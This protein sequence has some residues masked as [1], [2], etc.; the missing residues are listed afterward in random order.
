MDE[1]T[2]SRHRSELFPD[3]LFEDL[4][5]SDCGRPSIP[6]D[7]FDLVTVLQALKGSL[8]GSSTIAVMSPDGYRVAWKS[9]DRAVRTRL[10]SVSRPVPSDG[11]RDTKSP[12]P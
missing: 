4:F 3:E 9:A 5:S 6:G 2:A 10:G 8:R 7:V 11:A 12:R 1:L